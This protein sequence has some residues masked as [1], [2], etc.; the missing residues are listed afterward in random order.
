MPFSSAGFFFC[1][2]STTIPNWRSLLWDFERRRSGSFILDLTLLSLLDVS[3]YKDLLILEPDF[4]KRKKGEQFG[5]HITN[6]VVLVY[7]SCGT[8][9]IDRQQKPVLDL[10]LKRCEGDHVPLSF[11]SFILSATSS[12]PY[13]IIVACS[14]Y[15]KCSILGLFIFISFLGS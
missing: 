10:F 11:A 5:L 12:L 9:L 13:S 14:V 4:F 8:N 1:N 15:F 7:V 6:I 2:Y 3:L